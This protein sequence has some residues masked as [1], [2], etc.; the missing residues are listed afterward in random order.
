MRDARDRVVRHGAAQGFRRDFF[1]RDGLDDGRS[2][3][4]HLA[5]VLDHVDEV[6]DGRAVDSAARARS[7][8]DGDLRHDARSRRVAVED[9]RIARKRVNSFLDACTAR[10]VDA[11]ARSTHLHREIHDLPD[12]VR[13]LLAQGAALDRK[14]LR[15]SVNKAAVDRAVARDD[16]FARQFLLVLSEV[17]AAMLHEHVKLDEGVLVKELLDAL[18]S[19]HLALFM[20]LVDALLSAAQLD[21]FLLGVHE[22]D[23]FLNC[24]HTL[25]PLCRIFLVYSTL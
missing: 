9:A 4:E 12:L 10:V 3:N 2:R 22:G 11:D 17:R 19:R 14:V 16:A 18:A 15:E 20:L 25:P 23:F 6:R 7:H 24:S 21:M 13:V 5:R 8:D 1:R